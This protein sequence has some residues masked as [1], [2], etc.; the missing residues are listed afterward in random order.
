M[1]K[2]LEFDQE[3]TITLTIR[4]SELV[5]A[6]QGIA[7]TLPPSEPEGD[8]LENLKQ[9]AALLGRMFCAYHDGPHELSVAPSHRAEHLR[10]R[11]TV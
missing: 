11:G 7:Q 1:L 8:H 6:N 10:P 2:N 5:F 3:V 4:H 9:G